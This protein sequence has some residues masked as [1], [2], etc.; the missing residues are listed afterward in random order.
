[1][2]KDAKEKVREFDINKVTLECNK[3][4]R[5]YFKGKINMWKVQLFRLRL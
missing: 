1:L 4:C 3:I 2:G 5:R